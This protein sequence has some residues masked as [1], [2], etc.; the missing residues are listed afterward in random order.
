MKFK[1]GQIVSADIPFSNRRNISKNRFAVVIGQVD[2]TVKLLPIT[3][4]GGRITHDNDY[5]L[6]LDEEKVPKGINVLKNGNI[7]E[8]YGTI[9]LETVYYKDV[10]QVVDAM[11]SLDDLMLNKIINRYDEIIQRPFYQ[12]VFRDFSVNAPGD[13]EDMRTEMIA[14]R[15]NYLGIRENDNFQEIKSDRFEIKSIGAK[16]FGKDKLKIIDATMLNLSTQKETQ[17]QFATFKSFSEI[18]DTW[19]EP[20]TGI[21]WLKEDRKF[22]F[23]SKNIDKNLINIFKTINSPVVDFQEFLDKAKELRLEED[24]NELHN[25]NSPKR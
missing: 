10:S 6:R 24:K 7:N 13:F 21:E 23:L 1:T 16:I 18:A 22:K 20:K 17:H 3:S 4:K 11:G 2:S 19:A 15:I 9:K 5:S 8:L 12:K 25:S 14:K